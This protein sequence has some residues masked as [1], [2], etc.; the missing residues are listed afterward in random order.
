MQLFDVMCTLVGVLAVAVKG[1]DC[2]P[3]VDMSQGRGPFHVI[4][5]RNRP[6]HPSLRRPDLVMTDCR[7]L[8][9]ELS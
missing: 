1:E 5:V 6:L 7:L 3:V 9:E 8:F 2:T 4:D